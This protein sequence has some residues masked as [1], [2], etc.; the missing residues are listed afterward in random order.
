MLHWLKLFYIIQRNN[1]REDV[2]KS[3]EERGGAW[4]HQVYREAPT[5]GWGVWAEGR[6]DHV[7]RTS[8]EEWFEWQN[9]K[10]WWKVT[11]NNSVDWD[12]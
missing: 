12:K 1:K 2:E 7:K 5:K 3:E 10:D 8:E 6:L 4:L 11:Q 9:A